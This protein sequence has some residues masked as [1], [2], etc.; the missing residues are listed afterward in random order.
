MAHLKWGLWGYD[1]VR[2]EIRIMSTFLFF[3]IFFLN[4]LFLRFSTEGS[5][6]NNMMGVPILYLRHSLQIYRLSNQ[7]MDNNNIQT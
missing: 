6:P 1:E 4:E 5:S 3:Y 7:S 2:R